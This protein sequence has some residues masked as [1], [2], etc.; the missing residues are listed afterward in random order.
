MKRFLS[1][2]LPIMMVLSMGTACLAEAAQEP[3]QR[4]ILDT[5]MG[6][7]NDDAIVLFMLSQADSMGLVDFLGVTCV[8]GNSWV[9]AGTTASLRQLELIDRADIPVY[10]GCD[11]PIMG[12]RN[13]EA[14]E[15][16]WGAA[17][18]RGSYGSIATRPT[19]YLELPNE[20]RYGYPET[21]PQEEHAID[22]IIEQVHKYP[23]EVTIFVIGAGTNMAL[24]VRKDPTIVE[25]VKAIYYMGGA[26]DI[27]GN[28][29]AAAEFNWYYD[30]E[31][32]KICLNSAWNDQ[33]IVP[34]DIAESV[35]YTKAVYD[36]IAENQGN[37]ISTLIVEG[38]KTRFENNPDAQSYVWDSIVAAVYLKPEI[39]TRIDERYVDVDTSYGINY[40]RAI[41]WWTSR[42]RSVEEGTGMPFGVQKCRVLFDIDREMFWDFYVEMLTA[43][44]TQ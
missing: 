17:E 8:G 18:Y 38:Q 36:R 40:G 37:A 2:L 44:V 14:E 4:V 31:G 3:M 26:I 7:L 15:A 25:D 22:F 35:Y 29:N 11:T 6:Y 30:P 23:G 13:I 24:A 10:M 12:F 33:L 42:N 43:D 32:I 21:A 28:S 16:L 1:I 39:A 34:N 5:D 41:G 27:P 20:P 19:N 9:P